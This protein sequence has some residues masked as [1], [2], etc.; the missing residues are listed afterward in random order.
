MD[1]HRFNYQFTTVPSRPSERISDFEGD[2]PDESNLL[3]D[4]DEANAQSNTS[5]TLSIHQS[6]PLSG[7]SANWTKSPLLPAKANLT[8][9]PP[10]TSKTPELPDEINEVTQSKGHTLDRNTRVFMESRF[11]KTFSDVRVH[12]GAKADK[13][14]K[15]INAK[16]YTVGSDIAFRNSEYNPNSEAGRHLI[17]HELSHVVQQRSANPITQTKLLLSQPSDAAE[18]QADKVADSIIYGVGSIPNRFISSD[19][20]LHRAC[21]SSA[22]GIRTECDDRDPVFVSGHPTFRFNVGCDDF[23][24]GEETAL[25]TAAAA[26]PANGP[27]VI[28]GYASTDGDPTFN[29]NLSCARALKAESILSGAGGAGIAAGR[30]TKQHHGATAGPVAERRSVVI[31][32]TAAPTP[33]PPVPAPP[34][35]P[36]T[37]AFTRVQASSSP[38][39]MPDRIPPRID[40]IVGVGI[41]GWRPPMRP[42]TLSIDGAGGGNGTATIN[43]AATASLTSNAAV[44]LR[45]TTQTNVGNAGNLRLVAEQGG[46]RLASSNA[47]SVSAI[48][49][50][51]SITFNSLITGARRGIRVN[52]HW[53][54]DSGVIADLDQ[55]ERSEQVQYGPGSGIFAGVVGHNSGYLP[56]NASPRVDSH[57]VGTGALTGT[58]TLTANQ[59]FIFR[60]HRTGARDIPVRNSGFQ[61]S[62][63]A[64]Q[65][66]LGP[67]I[68]TTS[69]RGV[70]T[71]ANGFAS[72]AGAGS[73]TRTQIV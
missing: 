63:I 3:I 13:S 21:G 65:I 67:V 49:Q 26:L 64:L 72:A 32:A 14:A 52:N 35:L 2:E 25:R 16:A 33:S 31:Q 39:G 40:T 48:P 36:L 68:F 23:A 24:P 12:S 15:S 6:H 70:A 44:R 56:A 42:I 22:I 50:N 54:S 18:T 51:F 71:T 73:V 45:G 5:A 9:Q 55:A 38:A 47:F 69:K 61:I 27:I 34:P 20:M 11:S 59:T 41:V 8:Q 66:P 7:H 28:H 29:E 62:R 53:Q 46:T 60:D 57:G 58:G 37:V 43:G 10:H 17:A 19:T 1:E 4:S 30:I